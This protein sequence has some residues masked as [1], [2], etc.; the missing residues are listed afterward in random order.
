[1]NSEKLDE[2]LR[3]WF[4]EKEISMEEEVPYPLL[5]SVREADYIV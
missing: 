2:L 5:S 4:V 3:F 1:M